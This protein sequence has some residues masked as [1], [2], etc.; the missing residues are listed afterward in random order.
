[1][2]CSTSTAKDVLRF[3]GLGYWVHGERA[4]QH[5]QEVFSL[6]PLWP[7]WLKAIFDAQGM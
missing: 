4:R 7:L 2:A 6:C 3:C 1:M 5:P